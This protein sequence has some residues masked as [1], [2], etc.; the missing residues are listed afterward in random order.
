MLDDDRSG[1]SQWKL[2]Q[3]LEEAV[4][5]KSLT[6]DL[7]IAGLQLCWPA[8]KKPMYTFAGIE[9]P[10]LIRWLSIERRK[11][12]WSLRGAVSTLQEYQPVKEFGRVLGE[13]VEEF[14]RRF[15][16]DVRIAPRTILNLELLKLIPEERRTLYFW[17]VYEKYSDMQLF[18]FRDFKRVASAGLD[19]E[20]L[21]ELML[22]RIEAIPAPKPGVG[23]ELHDFVR[24]KPEPIPDH[25][26]T[27]EQKLLPRDDW[28]RWW[29]GPDSAWAVL[30]DE[31]L[32]GAMRTC[33]QKVPREI[34]GA[35]PALQTRFSDM[36]ISE[37]CELA[38]TQAGMFGWDQYYRRYVP[39]ATRFRLLEQ[40]LAKP[41]DLTSVF[42]SDRRT[43]LAVVML[44]MATELPASQVKQFLSDRRQHLTGLDLAKVYRSFWRRPEEQSEAFEIAEQWLRDVMVQEGYCFGELIWREYYNRRRGCTQRNL[45][46]VHQGTWFV[47]EQQFYVRGAASLSEGDQVIFHPKNGRQIAPGV[48]FI[49]FT[50]AQLA[51]TSW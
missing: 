51:D 22:A 41:F 23:S 32:F 43:A 2:V 11:T 8:E 49:H 50:P 12:H 28:R 3:L 21:Q 14:L 1:E 17:D 5:A 37:L 39:T 16:A 29:T 44:S 26:L 47:H 30:T 35:I 6:M 36:Q 20:I 38:A 40:N 7:I 27:E 18:Q 19:S 45:A 24:V 9:E 10:V 33:A 46:L 13:G 15:I 48:I 31:Q 34:F 42:D 4:E 25:L